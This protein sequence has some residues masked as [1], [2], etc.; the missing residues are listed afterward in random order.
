MGEEKRDA[1][2]VEEDPEKRGNEGERSVL[3]EKRNVVLVEADREEGN[4]EKRDALRGE[5]GRSDE[6]GQ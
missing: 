5:K 1:V 6:E 2:L 3:G 4:E